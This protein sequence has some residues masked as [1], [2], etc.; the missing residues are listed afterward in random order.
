MIKAHKR[1]KNKKEK[2]INMKTLTVTIAGPALSGK[3]ALGELLTGVL[4]AA[5]FAVDVDP[6]GYEEKTVSDVAG[7]LSRM[8]RE[9]TV[10]RVEFVKTA[11]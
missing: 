11:F 5:G 6:T 1:S 9:N 8:D 7:V 4:T 3:K 10:V 2:K